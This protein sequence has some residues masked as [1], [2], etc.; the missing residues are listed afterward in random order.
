MPVIEAIPFALDRDSLQYQGLISNLPDEIL[1]HI[2]SF[3]TTKESVA[4]SILSKRWI[5]LWHHVPNLIF[6]NI[7]VNGIQSNY[8]FNEFLF[9]VLIALDT[10]FINTFHLHIHYSN[11]NLAYHLS[12]PNVTK[13]INLVVQRKLNHLHL[14]LDNGNFYKF[15]PKL[16]TS[17]FTC[18]TLVSLNLCW[19]RVKGFSFSVN[20]IQL[21]SL[22]F[23]RLVSIKFLQVNDFVLLLA[24][25][26]ILED[27]E[28]SDI[29]FYDA[30]DYLTIQEYKNLS[31]P[32]LTRAHTSVFWCDFPARAFSNSESLSI[33]TTLYTNEEVRFNVNMMHDT[34]YFSLFP[35]FK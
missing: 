14:H 18:R 21:P 28:A 25:S 16:P 5:H 26:P 34:Q 11:P 30:K 23:L 22:T 31:F 15:L 1:I 4:T 33:D 19:F 2:L 27:L 6:P 10:N 17:I 32:K 20:G 7:T 12:F 24:G 9:S 29:Q 3:L 13:W 8:T 35:F